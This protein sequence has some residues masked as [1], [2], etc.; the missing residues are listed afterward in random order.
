ML[1]SP[2][3]PRCRIVLIAIAA[4]HLVLVVVERLRRR[5]HDG[6]ARVDAHRV[7]VLHVADGDAV[8]AE[9]AHHLVLDL[10]PALEVLLDEHL[11]DAAVEGASGGLVELRLGGDDAAALA[12]EREARRGA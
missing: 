10:L 3:M 8:V 1:H 11:G 4:E 6:L 2:T 7:E 5:D 9:V 12:A